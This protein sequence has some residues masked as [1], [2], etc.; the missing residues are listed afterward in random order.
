MTQG[1]AISSV[2][3][4]SIVRELIETKSVYFES[5]WMKKDRICCVVLRK[6]MHKFR[7]SQNPDVSNSF[8]HLRLPHS[9]WT[10]RKASDIF[11]LPL[12]PSGMSSKN[13]VLV[14]VQR[15]CCATASCEQFTSGSPASDAV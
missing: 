6:D 7:L 2:T 14:L 3:S 13:R 9:E 12:Q 10:L 15:K 8:E 5:T 1:Q 11:Y 4:E